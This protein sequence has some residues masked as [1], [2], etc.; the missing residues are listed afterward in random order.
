M[1]IEDVEFF[2]KDIKGIIRVRGKDVYNTGKISDYLLTNNELNAQVLN[3]AK[4]G[5]YN[6]SLEVDDEFDEGFIS[7][8]CNCPYFEENFDDCK[9]IAAVGYL[10]L[11]ILKG[12]KIDKSKINDLNKANNNNIIKINESV[13]YQFHIPSLEYWVI[14]NLLK[15]RA[16]GY[17]NTNSQVVLNDKIKSCSLSFT[18]NVICS[19]THIKK[20]FLEL[21]CNC[22]GLIASKICGHLYQLLMRT[23]SLHGK[24]YFKQ[25]D[26]YTAQ[27]NEI[28]IKYGL[29]LSD[30]LAEQFEFGWN[31]RG[32]LT[33]LKEP[34]NILKLAD[35][36][37]WQSKIGFFNAKI[38]EPNSA[39]VKKIP[40]DIKAVG[41]V[42][43]LEGKFKL[44]IW[45]DG[46]IVTEKKGKVSYKKYLLQTDNDLVLFSH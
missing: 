42:V 10:Y 8:E 26:D 32:D 45:L 31:N 23:G 11:D 37:N 16:N 2:L 34:K 3:S 6:V 30:E 29:N 28:L 46:V 7:G 22:N 43:L 9:H 35:H 5:C 25:Y 40:S 39:N 18:K 13:A 17:L 1:N 27:K 19:A 44:S 41:L 33:L 38:S 36:G 12:K 21:S 20:D 4:D 24:Y 15:Y 14:D